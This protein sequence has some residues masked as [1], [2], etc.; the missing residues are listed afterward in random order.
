MALSHARHPH[1]EAAVR[2][3]DTLGP[4]DALYFCRL[5][6]L[7]LFRLLTTRSAMG[8]DVLTQ[9]E[10]WKVYDLFFEDARFQFIEEPRSVETG[11]RRKTNRREVSAKQWADGYL[12]AFAESTGFCLVTF[13]K[14]LAK[15]TAA[16]LLLEA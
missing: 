8:V 2:W 11:F 3:I 15:Q 13:D 14:P 9:A 10:A 16:S 6:Q 4:E 1:Y 7:G 12:A 5:T